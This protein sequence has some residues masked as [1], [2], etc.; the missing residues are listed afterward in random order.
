MS[1]I[2]LSC[3]IR[4]SEIVHAPNHQNFYDSI[5]ESSKAVDILY[6]RDFATSKISILA[7]QYKTPQGIDSVL[8]YFGS[9]SLDTACSVFSSGGPIGEILFYR[10]T[11]RTELFA[12]FNFTFANNCTG[13]YKGIEG[14]SS[15]LTMSVYGK[16][17]LEELHHKVKSYWTKGM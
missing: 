8:L 3:N 13:F 6:Y 7:G 16:K 1:L 9:E 2:S 12:G 17:Y 4:R 15:K 11:S 14:T 5:R 10:D